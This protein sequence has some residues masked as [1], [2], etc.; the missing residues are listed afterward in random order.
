MPLEAAAEKTQVVL[1]NVGTVAFLDKEVLLVHDAVVRQHLDRF[2]P[3]RV[4]GLVFRLRE[5]EE[6]RQL[7]LV[8]HGN[9]RVLADDASVLHREQREF[10]FQRCC[11]HYISHTFPFFAVGE[12]NRRNFLRLMM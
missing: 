2:R 12:I 5:R 1:A 7:H 3:G 6:F 9:V 11:F 8:S 10:A 4:D